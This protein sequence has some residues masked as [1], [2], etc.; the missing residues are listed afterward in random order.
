[1]YGIDLSTFSGPEPD[2][3][4]RQISGKR[5]IAEA[6]ARRWLTA[7]GDLVTD[8]NAGID[9]RQILNAKI[10]DAALYMIGEAMQSEAEKDERVAQCIV[11][12]SFDHDSSSLTINGLID[13]ATAGDSFEMVFSLTSD[14]LSQLVIR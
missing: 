11:N 4:F 3:S 1:M 5:A 7:R 2:L 8:E 14:T 9:I 10:D 6:V 13:T 12:L